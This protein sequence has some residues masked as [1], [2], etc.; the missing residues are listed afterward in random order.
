MVNGFMLYVLV[1]V[2]IHAN[3][4]NIDVGYYLIISLICILIGESV[5]KKNKR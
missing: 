4:I 5:T 1:C 3:N 2:A